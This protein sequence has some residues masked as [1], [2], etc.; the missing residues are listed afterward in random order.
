MA[1]LLTILVFPE[2]VAGVDTRYA[3]K[4]QY[5]Q[6]SVFRRNLILLDEKRLLVP[7]GSSYASMCTQ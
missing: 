5:T 6:A 4:R 3:M 7:C 1:N 2:R